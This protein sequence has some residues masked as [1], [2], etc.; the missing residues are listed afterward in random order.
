[1]FI[2]WGSKRVEK[3]RGYVADF[4]PICRAVKPFAIYSVRRATHVYY[5]TLREGELIGH[6]G[7][8]EECGTK[9]PVNPLKYE[10]LLEQP[11]D[12]IENL[13]AMSYPRLRED[14]A[15]RLEVERKLR[16]REPLLPMERQRLLMEPFV[17]LANRVEDLYSKARLDRRSGMGCLITILLTMIFACVALATEGW[18]GGIMKLGLVVIVGG[19]LL[20]NLIQIQSAPKRIVRR[21][22]VPL[23]AQAIAPLRPQEQEVAKQ[24]EYLK[25]RGYKIGKI[26]KAEDVF[27][28]M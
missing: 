21:E 2:I 20:Y 25:K 27:N 26:V 6:I 18:V 9:I 1:M 14:K 28:A 10:R 7:K 4:C 23:L 12:N 22:I 13:I 8:C 11:G 24:L 5:I 16:S 15:E 19:G 3:K 17:L